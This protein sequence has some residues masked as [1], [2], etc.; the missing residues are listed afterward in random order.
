[1]FPTFHLKLFCYNF[2]FKFQTLYLFFSKIYDNFEILHFHFF[3]CFHAEIF[4][5]PL[6]LEP[7]SSK[8]TYVTFLWHFLLKHF[9]FWSTIYLSLITKPKRSDF[10]DKWCGNILTYITTN[11]LWCILWVG[12]YLKLI[13]LFVFHSVSCIQKAKPKWRTEW[14]N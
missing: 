9:A 6:F 5:P 7:Y 10:Q 4:P 1:M 3:K 8:K 11:T 14:F 13:F 12:R 2:S